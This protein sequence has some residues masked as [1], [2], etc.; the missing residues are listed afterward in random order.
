[1]FF[2]GT[3]TSYVAT[4]K[5][6]LLA[7]TNPCP[8]L[9]FTWRKV[10]LMHKVQSD[11]LCIVLHTFLLFTDRVF[12][13]RRT[14]TPP[15]KNRGGKKMGKPLWPLNEHGIRFASPM[16][17]HCG[18]EGKAWQVPVICPSRCFPCLSTCPPTSFCI[19]LDSVNPCAK[20]I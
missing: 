5:A 20:S 2:R 12:L 10:Q 19:K 17:S 14:L 13:P 8:N 4:L 7:P 15:L 3:L 18:S 6:I 1:M 16:I 9:S 11:R